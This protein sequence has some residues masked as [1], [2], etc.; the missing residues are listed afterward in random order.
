MSKPTI[1]IVP[2]SFA[3]P[4]IYKDIVENLRKAGFPAVALR[5]PSTLKRMPLPPAT[6]SDDANT[7]KGAVEAVIAQGKEVVVS[8]PPPPPEY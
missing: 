4:V 7:I 1:L 2:G 6:M 8:C 5:T 3:P